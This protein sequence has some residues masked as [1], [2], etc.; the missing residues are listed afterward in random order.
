MPAGQLHPGASPDCRAR[1]GDGD[2]SFSLH[3]RS[4]PPGL[5]QTPGCGR[6]RGSGCDPATLEPRRLLPFSSPSPSEAVDPRRV[7]GVQMVGMELRLLGR[8]VHAGW[9]LS[10][11]ELLSARLPPLPRP[12]LWFQGSAGRDTACVAFILTRLQC[13]R[14][15]DPCKCLPGGG[16]QASRTGGLDRMSGR[17]CERRTT[18]A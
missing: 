2:V 11:R 3:P 16:L 6:C 8:V 10:H 13:L 5:S 15:S 17:A 12:R 18:R 1:Q 14:G 9:K 4:P 7:H